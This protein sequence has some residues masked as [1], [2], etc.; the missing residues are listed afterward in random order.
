[1][2]INNPLQQ[3]M[4]IANKWLHNRNL[5]INIDKTAN[6]TFSTK[7]NNT[8]IPLIKLNDIRIQRLQK[9]KFLGMVFD[10][11]L[12]W[13]YHIQYVKTKCLAHSN[14]IKYN[15]KRW[16]GAHQQILTL[17]YNNLI[18]SK[19][20]Y[21][22]FLHEIKDKKYSEIINSLQYQI[23]KHISGI[24]GNISSHIL[25]NEMGILSRQWR[26]SIL[27]AKYIIKPLQNMQHPITPK[28]QLL[29]EK[30]NPY[31]ITKNQYWPSI[32]K[33]FEYF[34]NK[35]FVKLP[36]HS[37]LNTCFNIT[38]NIITPLEYI[39]HHRQIKV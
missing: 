38:Y 16:W 32:I 20:D 2:S 34:K 31:K 7:Q 3:A 11:R 21:G 24:S 1:M 10:E 6:I 28:I 14:K 17:L 27:S 29:A 23:I 39:R 19:I 33:T 26:N 5:V 35:E 25:T 36:L 22:C 15:S 13:K 4:E 9:Y 8:S 18:N 30:Y 12:T 37:L